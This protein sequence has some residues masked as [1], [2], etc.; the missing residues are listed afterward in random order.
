M[1]YNP[2]GAKEGATLPADILQDAVIVQLQ[3]GKV[4]DFVTDPEALKK[5]KK[6]EQ[7]AV[8]VTAE[9]VYDG[10]PFQTHKLFTYINDAEGKTIYSGKSDLA[11]FA[12]KYGTLPKL[13]GKVKV[14]TNQDGY[15]RIKLD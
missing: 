10:K 4:K 12:K 5:W 7:L 1:T 2:E 9:T 6:P 3:D 11:K 8:Q 13:Q 14:I 15:L